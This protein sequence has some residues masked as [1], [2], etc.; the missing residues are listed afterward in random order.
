[1]LSVDLPAIVVCLQMNTDL[2]GKWVGCI[3]FVGMLVVDTCT[4]R[5]VCSLHWFLDPSPVQAAC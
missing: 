2:I 1:M 3:E 4:C 5:L